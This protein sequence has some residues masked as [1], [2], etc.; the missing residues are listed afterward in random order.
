MTKPDIKSFLQQAVAAEKKRLQKESRASDSK[1]S[2]EGDAFAPT[3]EIL[4]K[5]CEAYPDKIHLSTSGP[6]AT[7]DVGRMRFEMRLLL[8]QAK[9]RIDLKHTITYS[10]GLEPTVRTRSFQT[11]SEMLDYVL[12]EISKEIA[13]IEV[14]EERRNPA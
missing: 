8:S 1:L 9:T 5:S 13:S 3:I 10:W 2:R 14:S 4:R 7:L 11:D 12:A 6:F